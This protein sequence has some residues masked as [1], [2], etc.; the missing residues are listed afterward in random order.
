MSDED[1]AILIKKSIKEA[2][3]TE[4]GQYKVDKE[5]HYLD[6]VLLADFREWYGDI[7]STFWKSL[8]KSIVVFM[9]AI[10]LLG[11]VVWSSIYGAA[12]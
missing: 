6:H 8:V 12:K 5:Q 9:F 10:M 11:F 1:I 7:K 2:V 4:L 3:N